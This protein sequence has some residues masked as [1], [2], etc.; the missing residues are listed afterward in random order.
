MIENQ[1]RRA[2]CVG[3]FEPAIRAEAVRQNR[4]PDEEQYRAWL[5][6]KDRRARGSVAIVGIELVVVAVIMLTVSV[7]MS[8]DAGSR[9]HVRMQ[10]AAVMRVQENAL[11]RG[12]AHQI[13]R[14][15]RKQ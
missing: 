12:Q 9:G 4:R 15:R 13:R 5:A 10:V 14:Q 7:T 2:V 8:G 3:R 6:A 11:G 1:R